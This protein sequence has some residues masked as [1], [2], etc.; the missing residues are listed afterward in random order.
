MINRYWLLIVGS[1]LLGFQPN[2]RS[3]WQ[4]TKDSPL[5]WVKYDPNLLSSNFSN[6]EFS[7]ANNPLEGV[8]D[9]QAMQAILEAIMADYNSLGSTFLRLAFY[10]VSGFGYTSVDSASFS[11]QA[12]ENRIIEVE[13]GKPGSAF[14]A[15]GE[16]KTELSGGDIVGCKIKIGSGTVKHAKEFKSTTTHEIAHCLGL[17]HS[18]NDTDSVLSYNRRSDLHDLGIDD[19]IGLTFLYPT[20]DSFNKETPTLGLA[21]TPK[22]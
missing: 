1:L 17:G 11:E 7:G 22:E 16:A 13:L 20:D 14:G 19:K 3:R 12:V 4:I 8:D 15:S 21:C 18:H 10:P 6:T 2:S 5:I 9:S